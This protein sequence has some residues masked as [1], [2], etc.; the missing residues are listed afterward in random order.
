[1]P[2]P[3]GTCWAETASASGRRDGG[4]GRHRVN[5]F[6]E[7]LCQLIVSAYAN[8]PVDE[9]FWTSRF[10]LHHPEHLAD[11]LQPHGCFERWYFGRRVIDVTDVIDISCTLVAMLVRAGSQRTGARHGVAAAEEFRIVTFG[12]MSAL[13]DSHGTRTHASD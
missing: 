1:V 5:V 8:T 6:E 3:T 10:D 7:T 2:R 12:G 4:I 9:A 13:L 11:G